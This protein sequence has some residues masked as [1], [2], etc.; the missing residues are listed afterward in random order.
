MDHCFRMSILPWILEK[1]PAMD[2]LLKIFGSHGLHIT[3]VDKT[4]V[5]GKRMMQMT[6]PNIC[7]I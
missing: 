6:E 1:D 2:L 5:H 4:I 7:H 3:M